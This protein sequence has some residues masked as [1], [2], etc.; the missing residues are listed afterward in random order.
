MKNL[1]NTQIA[2]SIISLLLY[3]CQ[4]SFGQG[5][6]T[7]FCIDDSLTFEDI[8]QST[9]CEEL[10]QITY[11]LYI[12]DGTPVTSSS[13]INPLSARQIGGILK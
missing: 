4:L 9:L 5:F 6:K 8:P 12:G 7:E 1:F 3:A 11:D 2:F 10:G 13:Q